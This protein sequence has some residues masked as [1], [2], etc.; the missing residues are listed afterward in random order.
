MEIEY[1]ELEIYHFC[2]SLPV[3][4]TVTLAPFRLSPHVLSKWS[5]NRRK[6]TPSR[7]G[8]ANARNMLLKRYLTTNPKWLQ[9]SFSTSCENGKCR[10][11]SSRSLSWNTSINRIIY[12]YRNANIL[13]AILFCCRSLAGALHTVYFWNI[14]SVTTSSFHRLFILW[15]LLWLAWFI[16]VHSIRWHTEWSAEW[17]KSMYAF[18]FM[19]D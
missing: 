7:S 18:A 11:I 8:E 16:A 9:S 15:Q 6:I 1:M 5:L 14:T 12:T 3:S 17:F 4:V 10:K 19:I 2:L 13:C